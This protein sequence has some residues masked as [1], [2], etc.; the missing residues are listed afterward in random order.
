MSKLSRAKPRWVDS[1]ELADGRTE[2]TD[3]CFSNWARI[4]V[5]PRVSG[6][7]AG[8]PGGGG[9]SGLPMIRS[10]IQAPRRTGDVA[11]PLAVTLSTLASVSYTPRGESSGRVLRQ[12]A[13]PPTA[14]RL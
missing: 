12:S 5:A 7:T 1:S 10:M 3:R 4:V 2:A 9:G 11:D 6:S 8:T 13:E 14:G